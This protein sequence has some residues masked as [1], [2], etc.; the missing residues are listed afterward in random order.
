MKKIM[1]IVLICALFSGCGNR[2]DVR[3]PYG[4]DESV[5]NSNDEKFISASLS[6]SFAK[7][8]AILTD[9]ENHMT[10][11]WIS[12]EAALLVDNTKNDVIFSNN[13]YERLYPASI[14]KILTA[15]VVLNYGNMDDTVTISKHAASITETGAKLVGFK[16]GDQINLLSLLE[17]FL[18]YSGNDA[19]IALAEHIAGTEEEFSNMMNDEARRVGAIHSN[20]VNSHGL[21]NDNHY[22]TAYDLYLIFDAL[23]EYEEFLTIINKSSVTISYL[24]ASG[25]FINKEY[26]TTN[27]YIKGT[28]EAPAG[29]TVIGGK[30]GT[31]NKAGNCL[32]LYSNDSEGNGYISVILKT[33]SGNSLF[34]QMTRLLQMIP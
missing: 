8:I 28:E 34:S 14:T 12:S 30:T 32:I 23:T 13:S 10:D 33:D 11:T 7:D 15:L 19:G 21:H 20:F 17:V 25:K 3:L 4:S 26:A 6:D 18:L 2:N 9:D 24:N 16:E 5:T 31:T 27:R 29:I 22:T 1:Y